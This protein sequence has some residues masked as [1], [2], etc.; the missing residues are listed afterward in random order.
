MNDK[1]FLWVEK[2]RPQTID[3]CILPES[4]KEIFQGFLEQSEIPNLLL[5]GSAGVGK[6]TSPRHCVQTL[7]TDYLV[8]NGSDEGRFSIPSVIR[9]RSSLRRYLSPPL[10]SIRSSLLMR[11]T[12]LHM[13]CRCFFV[14]ASKS[15]RKIVD[16]SSLVTTRI[17]SSPLCTHVALLLTSPS[18]VRRKQQWQ[19]HSSTVLKLS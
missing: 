19:V 5:A 16:S 7:G 14:L 13:M 3:E 18:R 2:Y 9:Q 15:F 1:L 12:T 4:T 8:I 11:Q 6:T 10:L 17:R